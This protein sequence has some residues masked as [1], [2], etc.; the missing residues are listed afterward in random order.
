MEMKELMI[1]VA[2]KYDMTDDAAW[3]ALDIYLR[4]IEEIDERTIDRDAI[5]TDD[6]DFLIEAVGSAHRAGSLGL[7]ELLALEELMPDV[8][9]AQD[10]MQYLEQARNDAIVA[11]LKAGA[12]V[13]DVAGAS[14]LSRQR[15]EQIQRDAR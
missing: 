1:R 13:K 14:G 9:R 2:A 4:Q 3:D 15:V 10:D 8:R 12:R 5:G 6:V 7:Q 11:A